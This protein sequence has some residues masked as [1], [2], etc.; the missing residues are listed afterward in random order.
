MP[1]RFAHPHLGYRPEVVRGC[2]WTLGL[3]DC[4]L[5]LLPIV[6]GFCVEDAFFILIY[7]K[8]NSNLLL[9]H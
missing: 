2:G 3:W 6:W 1:L 8:K 4:L 9:K 5:C 7:G